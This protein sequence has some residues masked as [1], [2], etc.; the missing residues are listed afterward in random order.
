MPKSSHQIVI[1]H[2]DQTIQLHHLKFL[3]INRHR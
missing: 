1:D 3:G 2:S